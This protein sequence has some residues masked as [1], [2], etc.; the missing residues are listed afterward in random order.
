[1]HWKSNIFVSAAVIGLLIQVAMAHA[2]TVVAL[3]AS[4]TAGKGVSPSQAYSAQLEAMLRVRVVGT[5]LGPG[6]TTT[7]QRSEISYE[8]WASGS[9]WY[10]PQC[11]AANHIGPMGYTS[12]RKD[13]TCSRSNWLDRS[14]MRCGNRAGIRCRS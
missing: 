8:L 7:H 1:M 4:N 6:R 13:T 2:T 5:T 11:F 3:G 12:L 14:P 10:E 9:F